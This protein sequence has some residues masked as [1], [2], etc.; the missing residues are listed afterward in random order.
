MAK[1][2]INP[3]HY[4]REGRKQCIE[5]II[6]YFG[7]DG[8]VIFAIC[9]AYKYRY[10]CG[11][12]DAEEQEMKKVE[13]YETFATAHVNECGVI[14]QNIYYVYTDLRVKGQI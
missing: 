4:Q 1:D 13:W 11:L 2:M 12:K 14:A 6:E 3:Q 9:N 5:E 8:A 7:I 10:R